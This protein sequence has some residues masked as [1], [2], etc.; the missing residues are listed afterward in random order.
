MDAADLVKRAGEGASAGRAFGPAYERDDCLIIPAVSV[1]TAGGG[2]GDS[3]AA[4]AEAE[5]QASNGDSSGG[6]GFFGVS[7]PLGVYV[8]KDGNVRWVPAIDATRL[9]VAGMALVRHLCRRR[10][11]HNARAT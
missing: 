9:A 5:A 10:S 3:K 8:V 7:W 4:A 1:I 2:G 11:R 6:G